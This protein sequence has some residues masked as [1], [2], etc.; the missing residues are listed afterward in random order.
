MGYDP[1]E[2]VSVVHFKL[3]FQH[4]V[5]IITSR[6]TILPLVYHSKD[7]QNWSVLFQVVYWSDVKERSIYRVHLYGYNLEVFLNVSSGIG[8][9]DGELKY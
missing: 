2:K 3:L 4:R 1:I 9:V 8:S 5:N 6:L 7:I